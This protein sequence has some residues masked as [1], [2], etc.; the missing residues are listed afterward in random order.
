MTQIIIFFIAIFGGFFFAPNTT[1]Y[2]LFP[3]KNYKKSC[4]FVLIEDF[5]SVLDIYWW[6]CI[7]LFYK[8]LQREKLEHPAIENPEQISLQV[9]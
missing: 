6:R 7:Y 3:G 5:I 4:F 1:L 2:M 8:M 9:V